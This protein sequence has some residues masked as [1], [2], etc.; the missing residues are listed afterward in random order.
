M[1]SWTISDDLGILPKLLSIISQ[2]LIQKNQTIS[3]NKLF[4][5]RISKNCC[6]IIF[7]ALSIL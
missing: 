1:N 4:V 6:D 2:T 7:N 3:Y 5:V